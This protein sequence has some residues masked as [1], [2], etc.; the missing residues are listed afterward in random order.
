LEWLGEL[1]ETVS[2]LQNLS[3]ERKTYYESN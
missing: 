3:I 2:C 1:V